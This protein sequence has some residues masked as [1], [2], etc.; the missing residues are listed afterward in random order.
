MTLTYNQTH[1]STFDLVRKKY[2]L[3]MSD[4]LFNMLTEKNFIVNK[5]ASKVLNQHRLADVETREDPSRYMSTAINRISFLA[6]RPVTLESE[7]IEAICRVIE[8][9]FNIMYSGFS[10]D[11]DFLNGSNGL[12]FIPLRDP[13]AS[14]IVGIDSGTHSQILDVSSELVTVVVALVDMPANEVFLTFNTTQF[15]AL[16]ILETDDYSITYQGIDLNLVSKTSFTMNDVIFVRFNI[17]MKN[18]YFYGS[19]STINMGINVYNRMSRHAIGANATEVREE[20]FRNPSFR[21]LKKSDA[22]GLFMAL[23]KA[24]IAITAISQAVRLDE[25]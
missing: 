19:T 9:Y 10:I 7:V 24:F 20:I 22:T 17:P 1:R 21:N 23:T 25:L 5:I 6:G 16:D 14:Q 2:Q 8:L 13:N 11:M 3:I 4:F 18:L 15:F 12:K